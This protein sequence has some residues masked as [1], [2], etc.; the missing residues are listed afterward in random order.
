MDLPRQ[1][2][3]PELVVEYKSDP[4]G[5][6]VELKS[7]CWR[8]GM[9]RTRYR[10][11]AK[12]LGD[13]C[14]RWECTALQQVVAEHTAN[15]TSFAELLHRRKTDLMTM[16]RS[17]ALEEKS[18]MA[19][20]G[21]KVKFS[22]QPDSSPDPDRMGRNFVI[23]LRNSLIATVVEH[24][25][26]VAGRILIGFEMGAPRVDLDRKDRSWIHGMERVRNSFQ[27]GK[28]LFALESGVYLVDQD[29]RDRS[30]PHSTSKEHNS[31]QIGTNRSPPVAQEASHTCSVAR[32][33]PHVRCRKLLAARQWHACPAGARLR[34]HGRPIPHPP[35]P[36]PLDH[37]G[38]GVYCMTKREASLDCPDTARHPPFA[39]RIPDD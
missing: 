21:R 4:Q 27:A 33:G 29:H 10:T 14:L 34:Q 22:D 35:H 6:A 7:S 11:Q 5:H 23:V 2:S 19:R 13:A 28:G 12:R 24:K 18:M 37:Y 36:A 32:R 15:R 31:I 8:V 16:A 20:M 26:V 25:P 39:S 30:L 38:A 9:Y 17:M 3:G 1:V